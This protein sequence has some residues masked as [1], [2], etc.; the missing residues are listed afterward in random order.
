MSRL[1]HVNY[2]LLFS[3]GVMFSLLL[4]SCRWLINWRVN[5]VRVCGL[6]WD[7]AH[8]T[9]PASR[10]LHA[11]QLQQLFGISRPA[12]TACEYY[13]T[14]QI[15]RHSCCSAHSVQNFMCR[16]WW[17]K[18]NTKMHWICRSCL[19]HFQTTHQLVHLRQLW[20]KQHYTA[21]HA[22][23]PIWTHASNIEMLISGSHWL[24]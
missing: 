19:T 23:K 2:W 16:I 10:L 7:V 17:A 20:R 18:M 3:I 22:L 11:R 6:R 12:I 5:A 9:P 4:G 8:L 13:C 24:N 21:L 15:I 14:T 1:I